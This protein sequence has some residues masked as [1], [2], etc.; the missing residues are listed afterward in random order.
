MI[1]QDIIEENQ[2]Q[3]PAPWISNIVLA[4]KSDG[5][6]R[7]TLDARNVNKAIKATNQ[8]IPKQE[9]IRVKLS[10]CEVFSKLDFK[11]AFWQIELEEESRYL[12]MFNAN[13]KL[14]RYKRLTMGVKPA[15]GE[16]NNALQP[17]FAH[18]PEAHLIHDDLIIA[19][20][21]NAEHAQVLKDVMT[22]ISRAGLTLNPS[23][24]FIG[25][26]DVLFWGMIYDKTV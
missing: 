19:T 10:G 11:S 21:T 2:S 9:D 15:Q 14:Y 26:S 4:P 16:L 25:K 23:K 6:I 7:M 24:C 3:E 18:I 12:T 22:A 20:K 13:G 1:E 17:V 8:P 5:S